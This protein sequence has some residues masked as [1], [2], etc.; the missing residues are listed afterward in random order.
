MSDDN[1]DKH[2]D[3]DEED[4][5][6]E[7]GFVADLINDEDE[8]EYVGR[9]RKGKKK[10]AKR[11]IGV[12]CCV[13]VCVLCVCVCVC[14][15][16][17]CVCVCGCF[18]RIA[19]IENACLSLLFV[20]RKDTNL[21]FAAPVTDAVAPMYSQII[22]WVKFCSVAVVWCK[23][24]EDVRWKG[25]FSTSVFISF[26]LVHHLF[27]L[28]KPMDFGTMRANIHNNRYTSVDEYEVCIVWELLLF[29]VFFFFLF[30]ACFFFFPLLVI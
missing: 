23:L 22:K 28:R 25:T 17:V 14:V 9:R 4:D 27:H 2:K 11:F 21:I 3:D 12:L 26:F 1:A 15:V 7:D 29:V 6:D 24:F 30:F 16:Y 13:C 10:R 18:L 19:C 8:E 5:D 20:N